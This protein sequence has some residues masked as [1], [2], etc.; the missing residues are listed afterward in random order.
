MRRQRRA[1][2]RARFRHARDAARRD[3]TLRPGAAAYLAGATAAK[4]SDMRAAVCRAFGEPLTIEEVAIDPPGPCQVAVRVEACAICH[5]DIAYADGAWGGALPAVYGHEAAG[6]V[7]AI[8]PGVRGFAPGDR[9]LVTLIRA[10][11]AC[12][13]CAAGAPTS[14]DARL[15]PAAEPAARRRRR[16]ARPGHEH[17]GLRRG[18][19]GRREPAACGCPTTCRR[20]RL[21]AR[22]RRHHRGR[23]GGQRRQAARPGASVAV[24]GAG[25]VGLNAIQGAA[26]AGAG[27]IVAVD[28]QPRRSSPPR[29]P[30][31]PPTACRPGPGAAR[32]DPRR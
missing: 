2:S 19:G 31:A 3:L 28:L 26:L 21:P 1:P 9:V 30:S 25:G 12:P 24:V 7:T 13:A 29:A 16:A 18:G 32:G 23:R 17:R 10:C 11:G 5:S 27:R 22:L 20:P 14:C 6:R 8:G 15:G 4:G